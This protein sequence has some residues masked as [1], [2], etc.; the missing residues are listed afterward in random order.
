MRLVAGIDSSTQ[1]CKVTVRDLD[2]GRS[3]R[4]GSAPHP[5]QTIVDPKVWWDALLAA[6]RAAGGLDDVLA[7]SVSGQQH[8]PIF[9]DAQGVP[10]A[11]SPLWNDLGSHPHMVALNTELG[12]DTWIRRTGLPL[13]LSDTVVKARWLRDEQPDAA[14]RTAAIAVVHDWLTWR[15]RGHGPGTGDVEALVTD[16][17]E[18]SGT[19][20]WSPETGEY[21]RDLVV[22]A[23]GHDVVLPAVLGPRATAGRT[24]PGLPGIPEGIPIGVGSGDNAAAALALGLE[25]GDAVLSLGT[26]GVVY[27]RTALPVHD[28]AGYVC[29]YADATGV[30]LPIVA[31]LN[32]ARNLQVGAEILGCTHD[33][34]ADLALSAEPG[35]GGLTLLPYF[36]GERT[37]DLPHAR[38]AVLGATLTNFTRPNLARAIVEGTVASQVAMLDALEGCGVRARRLLVIGGAAK[39]P[40]VQRVLA[41]LVSLP[42][43][44]PTPDE[45]VAK[46]AAMQAAV[47]LTG[48]FPA[49][50]V[51]TED[52]PPAPPAPQIRRQHHDAQ[53]ALGYVV[54]APV[55]VAASSSGVSAPV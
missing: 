48:A 32:A 30:H 12:R 51:R 34:L 44:V 13:S 36:E 49:W 31:T 29:N 7:V 16:R 37:P 25:E 35:A 53:V 28:Y 21:Q 50:P 43:L 4:E 52:V 54:P 41:E 45:Y 20:Y 19:G 11:P 24:G 27:A 22:H 42:I 46:G 47:A 40:A 17:S 18:A 23:L 38:G 1:S 39:N 14:A 10:T 55:E 6:V 33:E 15:L 3:V 26:S 2:T 5:S 8:T 9:L